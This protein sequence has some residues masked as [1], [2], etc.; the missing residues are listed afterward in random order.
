MS[1]AN[2][3]TAIVATLAVEFPGLRLSFGYIGNL[4]RYGDDRCWRVFTNVKDDG[5]RSV[6]FGYHGT[7]RLGDLLAR[8]ERGD[9]RAFCVRHAA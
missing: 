2:Q 7:D 8:I 5:G 6:S 3:I 9:L 1:T 4:E